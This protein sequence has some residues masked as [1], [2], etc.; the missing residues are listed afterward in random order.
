MASKH[1]ATVGIGSNVGDRKATVSGAIQQF[2]SCAEHHVLAIS[3][4]YETEPFGKKDQRWFINCVIRVET[5]QPMTPFFLFLQQTES[6]W[7]RK[8]NER[9]GPRTLDLD[10]LFFDDI[11]FTSEE[12]T[13]PHPGIPDRRFV[14]EPLCEIS[15]NLIHPSL[16]KSIKELLNDLKANGKI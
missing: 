3:S 9:W 2:T 7:N 12:L 13:L 5:I 1:I 4:F 8:R 11:V 10:L 16:R 6:M 15:P 14:L